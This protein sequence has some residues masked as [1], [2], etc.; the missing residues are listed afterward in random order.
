MWMLAVAIYISLKWLTWWR[1][2]TRIA[3]PTWR[4]LAYLLAWPGMDADTFLNEAPSTPP[5]AWEW[6]WAFFQTIL[7]AVLLWAVARH[8]PEHDPLT[9]GWA[10]MVGLILLL[11]FG[12]FQLL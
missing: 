8:I 2:R 10:G 3:H 7:G 4:S 9:R 11:H 1:A 12:F 6:L 5:T